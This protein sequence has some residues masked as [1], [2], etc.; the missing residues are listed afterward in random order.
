MLKNFLA[1]ILTGENFADSSFSESEMIDEYS[2]LSNGVLLS[3][4]RGS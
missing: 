4:A 1:N 3:K 2:L